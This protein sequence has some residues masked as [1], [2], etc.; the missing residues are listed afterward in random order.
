MLADLN[1]GKEDRNII[2]KQ[3]NEQTGF[4]F[5][6]TILTTSYWPTY[7]SFEVSIPMELE[8]K[9]KEGNITNNAKIK[10][11]I[12]LVIET[13]LSGEEDPLKE[14]RYPNV[15]IMIIDTDF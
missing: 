4:D 7:K 1:N 5:N 13:G 3:V 10:A 8:S 9:I 15:D 12:L 2:Q 14:K 11:S 6:V